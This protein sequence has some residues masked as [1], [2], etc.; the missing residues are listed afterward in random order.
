MMK[1]GGTGTICRM[2]EYEEPLFNIH[3]ASELYIR[4]TASFDINLRIVS[5]NTNTLTT[6][7]LINP[8][9]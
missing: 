7:V 1:R 5:Y 9:Q 2:L 6:N 3:N 8:K 4:F